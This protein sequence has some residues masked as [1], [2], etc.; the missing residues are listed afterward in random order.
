MQEALL[1]FANLQY[2]VL[3]I[4][5]MSPPLDPEQEVRQEVLCLL[6]IPQQRVKS[7]G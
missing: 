7:D 5:Q 6:Y 2:H 1:A 3:S 4:F